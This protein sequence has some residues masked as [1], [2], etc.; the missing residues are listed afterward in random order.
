[1]NGRKSVRAFTLI[2]L[3]VVVAIIALLISILLPSLQ[4]AREQGK[5]AYCLGNERGIGTACNAYA[6]EYNDLIIPIHQMMRRT[7]G[8][9]WKWRMVNWFAWGGRSGVK[10]FPGSA[11]GFILDD[12]TPYAARTRP[13]NR[14]ILGSIDQSDSKKMESFH[15]PSD[16]GLPTYQGTTQGHDWPKDMDELPCYDI[17]GSSYR[18][19]LF[20]FMNDSMAFAIGPYGKRLSTLPET[21]RLILIGEPHFF[22]MIGLD[23]G[24]VN[25]DPIFLYGW[26]KRLMTE[27]VIFCD[28]SARSTLASG[29]QSTDAATAA[30]M[31]VRSGDRDLI[32]RGPSWRFDTWPTPGARI[33]GA[34]YQPSKTHWPYA[35]YQDNMRD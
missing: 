15:C 31:N 14:Y 30:Q 5:R 29:R 35:G 26:H 8:A 9:F 18:G 28:G 20:S 10:P 2:E 7:T 17:I 34:P 22:E 11:G 33:W 16:R 19:S 25:P 12:T 21:S 4:G 24:T 13:L 32:S 3:L 6:S 1:M 27:N 23:N